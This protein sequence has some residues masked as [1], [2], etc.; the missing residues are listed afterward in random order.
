MKQM[1]LFI[2]I[3]SLCL[4]ASMLSAALGVWQAPTSSLLAA[5]GALAVEVTPTPDLQ[6]TIQAAIAATLT[7]QP[8]PT[9][10]LQATIAAGVL[11]TLTAQAAPAGPEPAAATATAHAALVAA[12]QTALAAAAPQ[13]PV[14]TSAPPLRPGVVLDFET[15]PNWRRGDE[16]YG[17]LTRSSEQAFQGNY[18]GRLSYNFPA[19]P[20][21]YV[22]FLA[23]PTQPIPGQPFGLSAWVYGNGSGHYLNAWIK[24]AAGE[25]RQY[26]FG[27]V[28]HNG[29][30]Q[31]TAWFDETT[32]WP[33]GH[34]SGPDDGRLSFPASLAALVLDGVPD[35]RASSGVIYLDE[36]TVVG[37][38]GVP[39]VILPTP[40][41]TS[42]P[43]P[44][45][46]ILPTPPPPY[47]VRLGNNVVYEPWG[48]PTSSDGCSEPY[49]DSYPMR[50]FT[51]QVLVTNLSSI[52]IPDGW[53]PEFISASGAP[54][55]PCV[56]HYHD[57]EV[58]PGETV[59]VTFATHLES[60]DWVRALV[61][62]FSL[63]TVRLCLD[64]SGHQVACEGEPAAWPQIGSLLVY[65]F[66]T[67]APF[68][69][70][71][72]AHGTQR[73]AWGGGPPAPQGFASWGATGLTL[74]DGSQPLRVLLTAPNQEAGG[75]ILGSY[76]LTQPIQAGD[77]LRGQVGLLWGQPDA[78]V[79]IFVMV[80]GTGV[81]DRVF[82]V[83]S[84]R[85]DGQLQAINVD[86]SRYAGLQQ[87]TLSAR[88]YAASPQ[89]IVAWVNLRLER[90]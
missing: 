24:D 89:N 7:G 6:A 77:H 20:N 67:Q 32:G 21:N 29:W 69:T 37:Q 41:V 18:S 71:Y 82:E 85:A 16:P 60:S 13:T 63:G 11:A 23:Q 45:V 48:R 90:P 40:P 74:E 35:N 38:G 3:L 14:T 84:K 2:V 73:L 65:D 49:D 87:I 61:F 25:V 19:V 28:M 42:L 22:V 27:K 4:G 15:G 47:Q 43:T 50:R 83:P 78:Q 76:T 30:E 51:V 57:T 44:P 33:N 54:L 62:N 66:Y 8:T 39:V 59:D 86:L 12:T 56:W 75:E 5:P 55:T 1:A 70:W 58:S 81:H 79:H 64:G 80:H 17:E 34:I 68:A 46:V 72:S 88:A 31:M 26:T 52:P 10:D 53:H 9:P 36:V